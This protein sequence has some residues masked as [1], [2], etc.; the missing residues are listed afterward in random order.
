VSRTRSQYVIRFDDEELVANQ[1]EGTPVLSYD[2]RAVMTAL[3]IS[4]DFDYFSLHSSG[5]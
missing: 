5:P 3:A 1:P 2:R 4:V